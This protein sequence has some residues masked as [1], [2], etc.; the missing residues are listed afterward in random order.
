MVVVVMGVI[1]SLLQNM[2]S[3]CFARVAWGGGEGAA[4]KSLLMSLGEKRQT[5]TTHQH[6]TRHH[7]TPRQNTLTTQHS[8]VQHNTTQH[9]ALCS[10]TALVGFVLQSMKRDRGYRKTATT[11]AYRGWRV[12]RKKTFPTSTRHGRRCLL[13]HISTHGS[14]CV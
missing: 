6:P 1:H 8:T 14:S 12:R 9:N 11:R 10:T 7:T 5:E 3:E 4:K 2:L 13:Y